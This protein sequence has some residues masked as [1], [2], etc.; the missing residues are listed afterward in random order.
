[1][2]YPF[3]ASRLAAVTLAFLGLAFSQA[4]SPAAAAVTEAQAL[5]AAQHG[6]QWIASQQ[7]SDGDLGSFGGDWSMTALA[8]AGVN[9]AD[10][11]ISPLDPSAQDFYL[12]SWTSKGPGGAATDDE[13]AILAGYAGG[14]QTSRLDAQ[15]NLLADLATRFDGHQ[16]GGR[17]ATNADAFGLLALDV[18]GAP[19]EVMG[20]LAQSLREQQDADGGWNF[21]AGAA[22][23]D[24][25]MTGAAIAAL[26]A[27]GA[28][29]QD[30]AL[31]RAFAYLHAA[32]DPATGGFVSSS[33]GLNTD[34]TG[35]VTSGLRRCGIDPGSW[36]TTQGK[37][38]LDFL[39]AQQNPDGSFQWRAGDGNEDLY[40]TQDAVRPLAGAAFTAP[41]PARVEG[42]EPAVRPAPTVAA[43][44]LVPMTLVIDSGGH[45]TGGSSI[46]MC[47]V[48]AAL[49]ATVAQV[50]Q[51]AN[52]SSSPSYCVSDLSLDGGRIARLNGVAGVPGRATWEVRREGGPA[53]ADTGGALG[54]GA[55]VQV[56]LVSTG[57]ETPIPLPEASVAGS[58]H[59]APVV[60][61]S[62]ATHA[63]TATGDS[64]P[65]RL[66][67][68]VGA[69]TR[70]RHGRVTI[71]LSC[72]RWPIG[73]PF[74]RRS[75]GAQ[76]CR[77]LV[78]IR[79]ELR[80]RRG[81]PVRSHIVG[82]HEVN[83]AAGASG[84]VTI[85]LSRAARRALRRR[86]D[87]VAWIVAAMR[88]PRSG[89]VTSAAASTVLR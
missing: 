6:A 88:D 8:S 74:D 73:D 68:R 70:V 49:G 4:A 14:L 26:C 44:T 10:V 2:R 18:S 52:N 71:E 45:V 20:T 39:L 80:A 59:T 43:G 21:A 41:A 72:P 60:V 22:T 17:G 1:M 13:R 75:V 61:S 24:V 84:T 53:E 12:S 16:L 37:T 78:R 47:K 38:P 69:L 28:A 57:G 66:R 58:A 32:Q 65:A 54:L 46:R 63:A 5:A 27:A 42:N 51:D 55:L 15:T 48:T 87:R 82:E 23:S 85:A 30:P 56:R 36:I 77:G 76:G 86:D 64:A 67:V 25:D 29:P 89:V 3:R 11:R 19:A 50:L 83:L 35:W 34:T 79:V 40:A 31:V 7:E 81:G 33:L 62:P 9:A